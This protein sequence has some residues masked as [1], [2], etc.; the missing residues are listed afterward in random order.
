MIVISTGT[1]VVLIVHI[2]WALSRK[3][4]NVIGKSDIA[5]LSA[6]KVFFYYLLI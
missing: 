6:Y 4:L 1:Y 2:W 3:M 5:I